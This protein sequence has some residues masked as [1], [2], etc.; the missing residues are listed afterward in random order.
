MIHLFG[1]GFG[2]M[3]ST[4]KVGTCRP[5]GA[6]RCASGSASAASTADAENRTTRFIEAI[7]GPE[8]YHSGVIHGILSP[9]RQ[10]LQQ[11]HTPTSTNSTETDGMAL[12]RS[13]PSTAGLYG[14][15]SIRHDREYAR[16]HEA[17]GRSAGRS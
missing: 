9:S 4:R 14:T 1:S 2:H 15:K 8:C 7:A 11:C 10:T 12:A 17:P 6:G 13:L 3:G 16:V 5:P